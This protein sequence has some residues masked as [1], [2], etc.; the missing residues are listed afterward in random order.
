MDSYAL[1]EKYKDRLLNY[2]KQV[3]AFEASKKKE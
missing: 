1:E 3:D 2:K